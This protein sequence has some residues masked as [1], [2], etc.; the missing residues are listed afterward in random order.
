MPGEAANKRDLQDLEVRL[1]SR[2]EALETRLLEQI[3]A[4]VSGSEEHLKEFGRDLQTELRK[5]IYGCTETMTVRQDGADG[6][7][8]E[9]QERLKIV[10]RRVSELEK[11]LN[12]PPAA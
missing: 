8:V 4:A 6:K 11:R 10:E 3:G 7:I 1:D 5:A 2:L 9:M 12:L